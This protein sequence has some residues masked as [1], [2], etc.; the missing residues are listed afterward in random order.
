MK[1]EGFHDRKNI[2]LNATVFLKGIY[3]FFNILIWYFETTP[4][5]FDLDLSVFVAVSNRDISGYQYAVG[6]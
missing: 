4:P 2:I 5:K 3:S 6:R 1:Q